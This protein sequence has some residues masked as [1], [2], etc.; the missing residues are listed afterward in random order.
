MSRRGPRRIYHRGRGRGRRSPVEWFKLIGLGAVL[1][2][3]V[4]YLVW[5]YVLQPK[6]A[7][8]AAG[9]FSVYLPLVLR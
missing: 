4:G 8:P 9:H 7:A 1:L 3:F 5:I 6:G 2:A